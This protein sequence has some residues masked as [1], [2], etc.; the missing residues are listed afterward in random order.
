MQLYNYRQRNLKTGI[1]LL[2]AILLLAGVIVLIISLFIEAEDDLQ[3][4][5]WV[6]I[7][8]F[9]AG[10]IIINIYEGTSID[11]ENKK[12]KDYVSLFGFKSGTWRNL[13]PL[14][15]IKLVP[16]EQKTTNT[17]NGVSPTLSFIK[18]SY[19]IIL[20]FSSENPIYT[21][22]YNNKAEAQIKYNLLSE[23]FLKNETDSGISSK[24]PNKTVI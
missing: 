20:F 16:I 4:P 10:L 7:S 15:T 6:G 5:L 1:H 9:L 14:K 13:P 17:P 2:G 24:N 19:Q 8:A 22:S 23:A 21:F 11:L 12:V 18:S 3:K